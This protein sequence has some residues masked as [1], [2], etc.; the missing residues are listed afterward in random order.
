MSRK[1]R[2]LAGVGALAVVVAFIAGIVVGGS[3]RLG[4]DIYSDVD[5]GHYA[6]EAIG[7]VTDQGLMQGAGNNRFLPESSIT[8]GQLALVLQRYNQLRADSPFTL[9]WGP[10]TGLGVF[11]RTMLDRGTIAVKVDNHPNARPQFGIGEAEAVVELPVESGVTRFI[12]LFHTVDSARVGPV[13][14]VRPTDP[15]LLKHLNTTVVASG[16]QQWIVDR[17]RSNAVGLIGESEV[18]G[19]RD[20]ARQAPHN[21]YVD[22]SRFRPVV[23]DSLFPNLPPPSLFRFSEMPSTAGGRTVS[24]VRVDWAP[25][26]VV[27]WRWSEGRWERHLPEGPHNWT[28]GGGVPGVITADTLVV[29]FSRLSQSRPPG[30][31]ASLPTMETTG[32][33]R[34][35]VFAQ[36]RVVEGRWERESTSQSFSLTLPDGSPIT[37]PP[38]R[39][40]ISLFPAGR[41]VS[42]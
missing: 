25:T 36:G 9:S 21:Y 5:A 4:S 15:H 8:R 30:G 26:N 19:F 17:F 11:D 20:R 33:G 2:L 1:H 18:G 29:L 14:S 13:R 7:W 40:W 35:L 41:S 42:W 31:G 38:G 37:V 23:Q 12:A 39:S 32:Q 22:T 3:S 10:L 27:T 16:G 34:A 24:E 6:D 28:R